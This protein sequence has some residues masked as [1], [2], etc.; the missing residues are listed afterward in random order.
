MDWIP[1]TVFIRGID[2]DPSRQEVLRAL[3]TVARGIGAEV[4]A[5]GIETDREFQAL[6]RIGIDY[7]QGYYFGAAVSGESD[8]PLQ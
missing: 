3:A 1:E 5:E 8:R 4:I 2:A 7:G 6:R